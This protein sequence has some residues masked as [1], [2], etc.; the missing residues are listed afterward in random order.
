MS[1]E[2]TNIVSEKGK[3]KRGSSGYYFFIQ[4]Q[5]A[6]LRLNNTPYTGSSASQDFIKEWEALTPEE[7]KKYNNRATSK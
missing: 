5:L 6:K 3:T 2:K 1:T 7:K 4:D